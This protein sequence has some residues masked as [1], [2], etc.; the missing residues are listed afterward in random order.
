MPRHPLPA[1]SV[2][3]RP[4]SCALAASAP[5]ACRAWLWRGGSEWRIDDLVA[6]AFGCP[7]RR[8]PKFLFVSPALVG[9]SVAQRVA[10][11]TPIALPALL[12]LSA[13]RFMRG[14]GDDRH[15]YGL[16]TETRLRCCPIAEAAHRSRCARPPCV[17]R[18]LSPTATVAALPTRRDDLDSL[19]RLSALVYGSL[20]MLLRNEDR[21]R[22]LARHLQALVQARRR[23]RRLVRVERI[24][25]ATSC[26]HASP[27][28]RT[29]LHPSPPPSSTVPGVVCD[30]GDADRRDGRLRDADADAFWQRRY[31]HSAAR[32]LPG[33]ANPAAVPSPFDYPREPGSM[34]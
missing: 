17:S 6:G 33:L 30:L 22:R 8:L 16:E 13:G 24:E 21:D 29:R 15:P 25:G 5:R 19:M 32:H 18:L 14:G 27:L 9:R 7:D 12:A 20:P 2:A 3:A 28:D 23:V 34:S 4:P 10:E 31:P 1:C 11:G 26:R